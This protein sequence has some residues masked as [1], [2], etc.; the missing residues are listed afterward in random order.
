MSDDE[1]G[2]DYGDYEDLGEGA[3]DEGQQDE[4]GEAEAEGQEAEPGEED[5]E[6]G[7]DE[8]AAGSDEDEEAGDE[9]E[10]AGDEGEDESVEPAG[11]SQK[12]HP[13]RLKV[14]PILRVSNKP[15][16]IIIV[17]ADERVTDNCLH[18]SEAAALI[19]L[20][21]EQIDKYASNFAET[22]GHLRDPVAI[23][24]KELY[25]R[26]C[27][28]KLRR[29]VG[30]GPRGEDIVEEWSPQEM[31]LPTLTPPGSL[32]SGAAGS[33]GG[34]ARVVPLRTWSAAGL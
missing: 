22:A 32:G 33:R 29:S 25:D 12:A 11:A 31:T 4:P 16:E 10:E 28:L 9:D 14:D 34:A 5:G 23:A 21:A 1:G 30:T 27:P 3:G 6:P 8:D 17:A 26:R 19:G 13:Q 2:E 20:R 18:R 7:L 24:Y 15:R